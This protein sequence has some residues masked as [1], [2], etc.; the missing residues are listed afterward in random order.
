[1]HGLAHLEGEVTA[2]REANEML[3]QRCR[4]KKKRLQ[5]GGSLRIQA[6]K[7]LQ[8]QRD[9]YGQF[10]NESHRN[11]GRMR[12]SGRAHDAVESVES[13]YIMVVHVRIK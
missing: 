10:Q 7:N 3:S 5:D 13:P 9:V 1:M 12:T 8:S 2:L 6:R 4:T 11:S